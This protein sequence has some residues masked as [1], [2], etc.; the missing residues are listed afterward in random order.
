MPTTLHREKESK[1]R[2]PVGTCHPMVLGAIEVLEEQGGGP[3][4]SVAIFRRGVEMNVFFANQYNSLR[5]RLSQ[6]CDLEQ[7]RVVRSKG[8]KVGVR[9]SRTTGWTLAETGLGVQKIPAN[10]GLLVVRRELSPAKLRHLERARADRTVRARNILIDDKLLTGAPEELKMVAGRTV[11]E[12]L[13]SRAVDEDAINWLLGRLP[14][15]PRFRTLLRAAMGVN[16]RRAVIQQYE[17]RTA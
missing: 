6:H 3:L 9:G 14:L 2:A 13:L 8:S 15:A 11:R 4:P 10:A 17:R 1:S 7:A 16:G 12:A 5:A